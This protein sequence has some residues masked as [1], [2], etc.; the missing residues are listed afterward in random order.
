MK[1][2][3][4][5]YIFLLFFSCKE[6][7]ESLPKP[8][9]DLSTYKSIM[10]DLIIAQKINEVI[11]EKDSTA[12]D[13]IALVYKQYHTDS[14]QLKKATDYYSQDP[15]NFVEIFISIKKDLKRKL[16]SLE[17]SPKSKKKNKIHTDSIK[18]KKPVVEKILNKEK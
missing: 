4:F 17:Q 1:K 3:F 12:Q 6:K 16:D 13:P 15:Q 5:L 2:F 14:L 8:D 7:K 10:K 18:I 9:M 11:V